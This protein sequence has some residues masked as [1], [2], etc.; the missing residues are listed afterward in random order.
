MKFPVRGTLCK[1]AQ[2]FDLKTY[3]TLM[4]GLKV[5]PW[6]CPICGREAKK[7]ILD[8]WIFE[9]IQR[10]T[11][12]NAIPYEIVFMKEGN[13]ILKVNKEK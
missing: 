6:R 11:L 5:R 8:H 1:H 2:C 13:I 12:V 9:L 3:L 4:S 10:V 7:F